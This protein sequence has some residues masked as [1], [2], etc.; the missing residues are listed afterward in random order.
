MALITIQFDNLHTEYTRT[1]NA[2]ATY[3]GYKALPPDGSANPL[4]KEQF[5][6]KV[7]KEIVRM[8]VRAVEEAA[9]A[10]DASSSSNGIDL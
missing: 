5:A 1:I 10:H 3:N 7:I 9:A 8:Q 6:R 2:I 4:T